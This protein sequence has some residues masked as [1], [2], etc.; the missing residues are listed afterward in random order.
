E[1]L[2]SILKS[3]SCCLKELNLSKNDL[4]DSG[5]KLLSE[6]L[7]SPDCKLET[8]GCQLST[9]SCEVLSSVLKSPSCL[10][11]LILNNNDLQD[12]GVKLLSEGLQSPD[13]KLETLGLERCNLSSGSC[14]VLSSVLKSPSCLKE[15]NLGDNDLQDSGVKLLSEGLQSPDC[16]L[17]TLRLWGCKLSTRSCEVLSSILRSP[18]CLKE[19]D[20]G[21][22]DLQDSGVKLLSEG[23]QSP[24]C[25]L[26]TLKLWSC[27]LSSGSCEVLSSV[28]KSPSC[29]KKLDLSCNDLQDSG[30]KLLSGGLQSPDCK[31]ET[32]CT[33]EASISGSI[34]GDE[35]TTLGS[36]HSTHTSFFSQQHVQ[37]NTVLEGHKGSGSELFVDS[38][39]S[40]LGPVAEALDVVMNIIN[41]I[42]VLVDGTPPADGA[43]PSG[44]NLVSQFIFIRHSSGYSNGVNVRGVQ[45]VEYISFLYTLSADLEEA[46]Q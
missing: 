21:H 11:V 33:S 31:L 5:V 16:K 39:K 24:D 8:L 1:V 28:L 10:K 41:T 29:L 26:E 7:Q 15:L 3:P 9:G 19:L 22:N 43:L 12:S 25:K 46:V 40:S 23:L 2:S 14:E 6:G 37:G 34:V 32:L 42:H 17:E 4:Q 27:R 30:V 45:S 13:C 36:K 44:C 20:L 35:G 18:S 38:F